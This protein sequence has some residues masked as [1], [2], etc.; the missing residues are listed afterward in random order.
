MFNLKVLCTHS[1]GQ[2]EI[3]ASAKKTLSLSLLTRATVVERGQAPVCCCSCFPAPFS[4]F[5]VC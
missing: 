3:G 2:R 4:F 1:L 5:G